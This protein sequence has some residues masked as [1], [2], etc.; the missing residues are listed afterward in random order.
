VLVAGGGVWAAG[1]VPA[2]V[3]AL[4]EGVLKAMLLGKLKSLGAVL[5]LAAVAAGVGLTYRT[6]GAQTGRPAAPGAAR[7]TADDLEELRLEVAALR[8]GLQATRERVKAL[9][10]E[11]EAL[12]GRRVQGAGMAPS[13]GGKVE[14]G[15][16]TGAAT[17]TPAEALQR[18]LIQLIKKGYRTPEPRPKADPTIQGFRLEK[19]PEPKEAPDA[20]GEV[21]AALKRLRDYP[22]D[23]EAVAALE[24]A[25]ARARPG[26]KQKPGPESPPLRK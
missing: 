24:N 19:N 4:T 18:Q 15:M 11:V 5:L 12:K 2:Q 10:G 6:A 8:H 25:L 3:E 16:D 1:A 9:E 23:K 13:G 26:A 21:D 14:G 22:N 17:N 7:V 20:W